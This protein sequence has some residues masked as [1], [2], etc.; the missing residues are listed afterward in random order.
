MIH[1]LGIDPAVEIDSDQRADLLRRWHREFG[2]RYGKQPD[3]KG[4]LGDGDIDSGDPRAELLRSW[5]QGSSSRYGS[6]P[7]V[8]GDLEGN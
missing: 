2:S 4:D 1:D 7:D 5:H 8:K 3:V 6:E